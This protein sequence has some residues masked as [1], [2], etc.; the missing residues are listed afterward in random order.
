MVGVG[1]YPTLA[2][3]FEISKGSEAAPPQEHPADDAAFAKYAALYK[4]LK[5]VR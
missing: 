3:A 2:E 5:A 1:A 4:A